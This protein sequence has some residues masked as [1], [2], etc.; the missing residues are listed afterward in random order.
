MR[1]DARFPHD[2][3]AVRALPR[4]AHRARSGAARAAEGLVDHRLPGGETV[5][6]APRAEPCAACGSLTHWVAVSFETNVCSE[7]CLAEMDAAFTKALHAA[8]VRDGGMDQAGRTLLALFN[9][10]G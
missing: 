6:C 8:V 5:F 10:I 3:A 4:F 1:F 9:G 7:E 2:A